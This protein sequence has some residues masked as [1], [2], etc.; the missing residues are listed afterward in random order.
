MNV[1]KR[2]AARVKATLTPRTEQNTFLNSSVRITTANGEVTFL[3][4]DGKD[5]DPESEQGGKVLKD[6]ESIKRAMGG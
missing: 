3:Q 1:F 5:V 6:Y 4:V 2:I